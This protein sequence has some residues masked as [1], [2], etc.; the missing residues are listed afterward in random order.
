MGEIFFGPPSLQL[1]RTF[2]RF[3]YGI[4]C[5]QWHSR[6]MTIRYLT[7]EG[8]FPRYGRGQAPVLLVR[9]AAIHVQGRH[10]SDL[11]P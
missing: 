3:R 4:D 7:T 9:Y 11:P 10:E 8:N 6:S 1:D 5:S 2:D